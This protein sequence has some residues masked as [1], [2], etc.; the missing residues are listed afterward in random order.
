MLLI[1]LGHKAQ[2]GKDTFAEECK[3][4]FGA[5]IKI[6]LHSFAD[7]LREEVRQAARACFADLCPGV[8]FDPQ[9]ALR[10]LCLTHDVE[11]EENAKPDVD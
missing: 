5:D 9:K 7:P 1:G 8:E 10:L 6:G 11:F 3:R 2:Q 4:L